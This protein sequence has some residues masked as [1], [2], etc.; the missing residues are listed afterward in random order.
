[1]I[2]EECD[3]LGI[4]SPYSYIV[5]EETMVYACPHQLFFKGLQQLNP[6]GL[7]QLMRLA[8]QKIK[9][10]G[11]LAKQKIRCDNIA[12]NGFSE[13]KA[14]KDKDEQNLAKVHQQFPAGDQNISNTLKNIIALKTQAGET[15]SYK[16]MQQQQTRGFIDIED[17]KHLNKL[18][19]DLFPDYNILERHLEN[20]SDKR[21]NKQPRHP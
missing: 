18:K 2:G 5:T 14:A 20:L 15:Q 6:D 1:M 11:Q 3:L 21:H 10:Y 4:A 9:R 7:V 8:S 16:N 19:Q 13:V 17:I 12:E